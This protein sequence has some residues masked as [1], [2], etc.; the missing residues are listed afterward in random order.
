MAE[1]VKIKFPRF[2]ELQLNR[3][4]EILGNLG[5]VFFAAIVIPTFITPTYDIFTGLAGFA[6]SL[7]CWFLSVVL[8]KTEEK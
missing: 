4:S 1:K 3:I 5:I 7:V 6:I 8:L 2:N